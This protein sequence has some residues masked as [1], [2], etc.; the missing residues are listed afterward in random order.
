MVLWT[1]GGSD[2]VVR[3]ESDQAPNQCAQAIVSDGDSVVVVG[4]R[5]DADGRPQGVILRFEVERGALGV[6]LDEVVELTVDD[7]ILRSVAVHDGDVHVGGSR[8]DDEQRRTA[9]VWRLEG[10]QL[11]TV[12]LDRSQAN[13]INA[14]AS[15]GRRLWAAGG[16][17][18]QGAARIW[19]TEPNGTTLERVRVSLGEVESLQSLTFHNGQ[20][21]AFGSAEAVG[22]EIRAAVAVFSGLRGVFARDLLIAF[23]PVPPYVLALGGIL[24]GLV[25]RRGRS[26]AESRR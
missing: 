22:G 6:E 2:W 16:G 20:L 5:D 25:H 17:A 13:R 26:A 21:S 11:L 4:Y 7:A 15:D 19:A 23:W 9:A 8:V 24:Y 1:T 3:H 18:G 14:L 12:P 10:D